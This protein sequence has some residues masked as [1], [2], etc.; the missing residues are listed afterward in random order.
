VRWRF[1]S[2]FGLANVDIA[3]ITLLGGA[4]Y[5]IGFLIVGGITVVCWPPDIASWTS[6][7]AL[8]AIGAAVLVV[9]ASAIGAL[10]WWKKPLSWRQWTLPPLAIAPTLELLLIACVDWLLVI[11]VVWVLLPPLAGVSFVRFLG[12]FMLSLAAGN[13]SQV[14]GGLGVL[15]ASLLLM[16]GGHGAT[17]AI[18]GALLAYRAIYFLLPFISAMALLCAIEGMRNRVRLGRAWMALTRLRRPLLPQAAAAIVFIAGA[19]VLLSGAAPPTSQRAGFLSAHL[20]YVVID[21]AR[22]AAS[23]G[24]MA[25]LFAGRGLQLRRRGSWLA[26]I[27]LMPL[28]AACCAIKGLDLEEAAILLGCMAL[29]AP[30]SRAFTRRVPAPAPTLRWVLAA[31]TVLLCAFWVTWFCFHHA[32]LLGGRAWWR[33]AESTDAARSLRADL[34]ALATFLVVVTW[35]ALRPE[36]VAPARTAAPAASAPEAREPH[37]GPAAR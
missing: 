23:V 24:G 18:A 32:P 10:L 15:E 1:Y 30:F 8:R 2:S 26:A 20:P 9:V 11:G 33:S 21:G 7:V 31:G 36:R 3:V 25:L 4:A 12:C 16:L 19:V 35:R 17:P 6:P 34:A 22:L 27:A 13:V 37:G 5:W 28:C 14:P 29:I